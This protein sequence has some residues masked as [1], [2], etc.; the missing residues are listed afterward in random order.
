MCV[1]DVR[2]D[3]VKYKDL[4]PCNSTEVLTDPGVINGGRRL[5]LYG[6]GSISTDIADT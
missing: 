3:P 4:Y 2:T 1:N 5:P 6:T